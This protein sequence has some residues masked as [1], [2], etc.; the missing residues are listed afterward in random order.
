MSKLDEILG[1]YRIDLPGTCCSNDDCD[2]YHPLD[3]KQQAAASEATTKQIKALFLDLL[4]EDELPS[5]TYDK[6]RSLGQALNA[7]GRNALR[8][9]LREKMEKL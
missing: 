5:K 9:E 8:S 4:G 6:N 1:D 7:D 3:D 2:G